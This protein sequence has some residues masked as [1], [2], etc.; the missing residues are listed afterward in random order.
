MT[1][2]ACYGLRFVGIDGAARYLYPATD[3]PVLTVKQE[4]GFAGPR[5]EEELAEHTARLHL[6]DGTGVAELDR[7]GLT[8]TLRV[9]EAY[10][11]EALL[12]PMLSSTAAVMSR[13]LGRDSFHAGVFVLDGT[14]WVLTGDKGDGKSTTLGYLARHGVPVLADDLAVESNG[15]IFTGP[16]FIDLRTEAAAVLGGGRDLGMLG[17]RARTRLDLT[18]DAAPASSYPLGGWIQLGWGEQLVLTPVPLAERL[19]LLFRNS[20]VQR[21][22]VD[23]SSY[24]RHAARPFYRLT[25][26]R[27]LD[28]LPAVLELLQARLR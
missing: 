11:D 6:S 14:A 22:P 10:P 18:G 2:W 24:L 7:A 13:W 9:R 5:G 19:G 23:P 20:A 21:P 27:G 8:A 4:L 16:G 1:G 25:R 26:P 3:E 15:R 28:G 12:H 17:A